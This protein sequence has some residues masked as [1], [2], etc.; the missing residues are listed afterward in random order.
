MTSGARDCSLSNKTLKL[1]F[2]L[3]FIVSDVCMYH[4]LM[5]KASTRYVLIM[6]VISDGLFFLYYISALTT[7][8]QGPIFQN[9]YLLSGLLKKG[10]F[11]ILT[12]AFLT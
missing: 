5:D 2:Y 7:S 12:E 8:R 9:N 4:F 3:L 11:R 10:E 6:H 1:C